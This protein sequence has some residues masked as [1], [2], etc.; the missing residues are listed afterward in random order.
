MKRIGKELWYMIDSKLYMNIF[1][2]LDM[3]VR[4][5]I[6]GLISIS[7]REQIANIIYWA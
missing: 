6:K 7:I 3:V 2:R 4:S 1:L 5:N